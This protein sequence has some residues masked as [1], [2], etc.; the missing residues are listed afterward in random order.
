[1]ALKMATPF[2]RPETGVY[3]FRKAVPHK[4]RHLVGKSEEYISLGTSD[5]KEA[6]II[7]P[8]VAAE[9]QERWDALIA[10]RP[11]LSKKHIQG[12]AGEFYRW[13]IAK[14]D[15]DP[16]QAEKWLAEAEHD[17][18]IMKPR[19]NGFG[20]G[21]PLY[22]KP[23]V[24]F[25]EER[26]L[27]IDDGDF[28]DLCYAAGSAG[29]QAKE[30][31]ARNAKGDYSPDPD[32][33]EQRFPKWEHVEPDT[34]SSSRRLTLNLHW[35]DYVKERAPSAGTVKRWRPVLEKLAA[36]AGSDDLGKV[37][38]AVLL[39]W[40]TALLNEGLSPKTV[41]EVN[42]AAARSFLSWAEENKK[43]ARNPALDVK[44]KIP[45]NY[46]E[47]QATVSPSFHPANSR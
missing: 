37:T 34:V 10:E 35:N 27:V 15:K 1:M 38:T 47:E 11:R 6:R 21:G 45:K 36:F 23:V 33:G 44:V 43:I 13:L 17:R 5:A 28:F 46:Q 8:R 16:G 22:H 41:K 25:L 26:K 29:V 30:H 19:P 18:R 2:K 31:L 4:I 12:L 32:P 9:V 14:H 40:K 3:Y 24:E 39:K 7:F 42:I 20:A